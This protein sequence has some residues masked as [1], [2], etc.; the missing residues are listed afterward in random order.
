MD[1]G[2]L[3]TWVRWSISSPVS[4]PASRDSWVDRPSSARRSSRAYALP[5]R[6][7]ENSSGLSWVSSRWREGSSS[8]RRSTPSSARAERMF[9]YRRPRD[10]GW[11]WMAGVRS[12]RSCCFC[13][14]LRRRWKAFLTSWATA[15]GETPAVSAA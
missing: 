15:S 8:S 13:S 4:S 9:S 3:A 11:S 7:E 12:R 10:L 5:S 1:S 14:F 6:G 2:E